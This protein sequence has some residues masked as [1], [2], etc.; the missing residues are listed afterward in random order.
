MSKNIV[1]IGMPGCGKSTLSKI[2]AKKLNKPVIDMD[3]YIESYEKKTIKEMF[4]ISETFFRDME[5]KYSILLG[6]LDSHIIATGG[7]IVKRK[8]NIIN[9][10]KNSVVVFINRPVEDILG[11]IEVNMRPLLAEGVNAI[12]TLYNERM[13]L[14]KEYCDIEVSNEVEIEDVADLIIEKVRECL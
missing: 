3:D 4:D 13:E 2:I 6:K 9:L 12:Y 8:D 10:K 7:G 1:L 5:S 11:D 14:Y